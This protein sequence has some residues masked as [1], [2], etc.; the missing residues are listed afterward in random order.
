MKKRLIQL[1]IGQ[2]ILTFGISLMIVADLGV[3]SWDTVYLGLKEHIGGTYGV[4]CFLVQI[5]V[6]FLSSFILR[7]IPDWKALI[8]VVLSSVLVDIWFA[9][10]FNGVEVETLSV[11]IIL[12]GL[13]IFLLALGIAV[14]VRTNLFKAPFDEFMVATATKLKVSFALGRTINEFIAV[15]VGFILGGPVGLGT[16]VSSLCLGYAL[17]ACMK[18]LDKLKEKGLLYA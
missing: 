9:T 11:R 5:F 8:I 7:K 2:L 6:L 13:G 1:M 18:G 3:S 10:L 15:L 4:W 17:Q 14:Y 12:F 16:I